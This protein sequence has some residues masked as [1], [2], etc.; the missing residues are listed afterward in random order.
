[1]LR[2]VFGALLLL[3]GLIHLAWF[4][5]KQ[6]DESYPFRWHSLMFPKASDATMK[7]AVS[8]MIVVQ[9]VLFALAALG[10][11]G[12]PGLAA[13]WV[14]AAVAGALV[15]TAVMALLWHPWFVTGPVVNL[16]IVAV[17]VLGFIQ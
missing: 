13:I 12:A 3:H 2:V 17:A 14:P 7:R 5:P 15:S 4:A 10:V 11:W 1:M 8:P 9:A 16:L 6:P